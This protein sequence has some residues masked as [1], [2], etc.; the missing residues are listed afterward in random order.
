MRKFSKS[1]ELW[2]KAKKLVPGGMPKH[3]SPLNLVPGNS[4]CF[5]ERAQGC[6]F[7]DVDGHEYIDYLCAYGPM[8][9]GYGHPKVETAVAEQRS[10][11]D[12]LS[13]PSPIWI[14]LASCM[15]DTIAAADWVTFG[16]NG[17]DVCNLSIRVARAH[18]G[19]KKIV[20]AAGAYHG[21]GA[22]CTPFPEGI[23]ETER[24]DI[25]YFPYNDAK[26]LEQLLETTG[27]DVAAVI[28]TPF[29]HEVGHDQEMPSEA[30]I[31]CLNTQTSSEGPLLIVDDVR[32]GLRLHIAGSSEYFGLRPHL[33]CFS[34]AI[35]NGYPV[36]ALC[37]VRELKKAANRVFFTGSFFAGAEALAAAL[38][39]IQEMKATDG[40]GHI[41]RVGEMLKAGMLKQA[42]DLELKINYTGPATIPFMSFAN[43]PQFDKSRIFCAAA[44][45]EGA[46]FHP[47]HNWFISAAHKKADIEETLAATAKA[48]AVVKEL[49]KAG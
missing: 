4:P 24:A 44:Y 20:M 42:A 46:F 35:G 13:L 49:E 31:N 21:I 5:I 18:T 22:W 38:A 12:C 43:D 2:S 25:L 9:L 17:S 19:R 48:F 10:K 39:T 3:L 11:G 14:D 30:F 16:K 29:K 26:A 36:S 41:F 6:R 8:I 15:A 34:K 47:T 33:S 1:E 27:A 32:A 23:T 37:G 40:I 7:W 45:Q 28:V